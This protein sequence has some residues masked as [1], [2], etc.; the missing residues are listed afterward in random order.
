MTSE[1]RQTERS[2]E[3]TCKCEPEKGNDKNESQSQ[4]Q[5][6]GGRGE[7]RVGGGGRGRQNGESERE[8][9]ERGGGV[10]VVCVRGGPEE[11]LGDQSAARVKRAAVRRVRRFP[12]SKNRR[13]EESESSRVAVHCSTDSQG[14]LH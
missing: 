12:F 6:E 8:R 1:T 13:R 7:A 4:S 11:D 3:S 5:R 9:E 2:R 10:C 14:E